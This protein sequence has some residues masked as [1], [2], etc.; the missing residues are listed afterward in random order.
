MNEDKRVVIDKQPEDSDPLTFHKVGER[1][2][3]WEWDVEYVTVKEARE[4]GAVA[5]SKCF[6]SEEGIQYDFPYLS[7]HGV[8]A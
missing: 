4:M 8:V 6:E 1:G 5:C 2:S 7:K 3:E